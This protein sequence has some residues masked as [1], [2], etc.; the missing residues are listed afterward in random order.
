MEMGGTGGEGSVRLVPYRWAGLRVGGPGIEAD[1]PRRLSPQLGQEGRTP[2]RAPDFYEDY[3]DFI[4]ALVSR[5]SSRN[6]L[7]RIWAI[8]IWN[9]P[10]LS[11]V[12]P[13]EA[14]ANPAYGGHR[15]FTFRRTEDLRDI[16]VRNGDGGKQV[17]I[18]EFGWTRQHSSYHLAPPTVP[19]AAR[20][21]WI[22]VFP[23]PLARM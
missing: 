10:N 13:E 19:I 12:S 9:E 21:G 15:V 6:P 3:A 1:G 7:G 8:E 2:R 22:M 4:N 18:T 23:P 16:M 20:A 17:W 11:T 14:A 5:Y